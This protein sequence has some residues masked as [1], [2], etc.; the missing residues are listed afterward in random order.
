MITDSEWSDRLAKVVLDQLASEGKL[1]EE[2]Q[3][4]ILVREADGTTENVSFVTN[5]ID[6]ELV[7]LLVTGLVRAMQEPT[8]MGTVALI[9]RET[10]RI[11][12]PNDN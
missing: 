6:G 8:C 7:K 2:F 10:G 3:L 4:C 5:V 9:D 11:V 1:P 12:R